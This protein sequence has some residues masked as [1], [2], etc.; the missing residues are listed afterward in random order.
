MVLISYPSILLSL[1]IKAIQEGADASLPLLLSPTVVHV[2]GKI[3]Y[4]EINDP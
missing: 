2:D 3:N 4:F 1:S